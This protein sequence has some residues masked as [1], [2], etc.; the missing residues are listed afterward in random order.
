MRIEGRRTE[1]GEITGVGRGSGGRRG[2]DR[3]RG[4]IGILGVGRVVRAVIGGGVTGGE[5]GCG[6]VR[7]WVWIGSVRVGVGVGVLEV[8]ELI[9]WSGGV[10]SLLHR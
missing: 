10:I 6:G 5:G 1:G 7:D 3:G 8:R 9:V 4:R 2:R